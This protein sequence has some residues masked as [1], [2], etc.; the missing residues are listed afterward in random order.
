M[1]PADLLRKLR[2]LEAEYVHACAHQ[3]GEPVENAYDD[4]ALAMVENSTELLGSLAAL[5]CERSSRVR[6][7]EA[8][9]VK[10]AQKWNRTRRADSPEWPTGNGHLLGCLHD[11]V[12]ALESFLRKDGR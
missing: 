12:D 9:V 10:A 11:A 1:S 5:E 2:S 3:H 4:F 7:L 8:A 6:E